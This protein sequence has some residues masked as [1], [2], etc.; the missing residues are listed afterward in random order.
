MKDPHAT[1]NLN[2]LSRLDYS[3]VQQ[4][5]HC[6]MCLPDCPTYRETGRERNS[7]RG[8]IALMRAVADGELEV[9]RAFG[10]EMY[11]C[12]GCLACQ[13]ACPADVDY[14]KLFEHARA[15]VE[16]AGAQDSPRRQVYRFLTLRLLFRFPRLL[17]WTARVLRA[18]QRSGLA[19]RVRSSGLIPPHLRHLEPNTPTIAPRFSNRL[20]APSE[21]PAGSPPRYRVAL[22]TGCI[23]DIA[24]PSVNRDCVDVL[25]AAGCQVETPPVQ[26]CCGSLHAHNGDLPG[27]RA[28][29]R[30]QLDLFSPLDRFDAILSNAGGCGSHLKHYAG[31]LP[32]DPRAHQ[33][34]AKLKDIHEFLAHIGIPAPTGERPP[35]TVAYQP[36]CHLYHGQRIRSQPEEILSRIPGLRLVPFADATTCCGSAG[37]YSITHPTT[38]QNLV[39]T[40][41][42]H[43][44]AA[45]ASAIATANPGCQLQLQNALRRR[46][47]D[48]RVAHPLTLLAEALR[49]P[50]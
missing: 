18:Y 36:S 40:K 43:I 45:G 11:Y 46:S 25:V 2:P 28:L 16:E 4:C 49:T 44:L 10:E 20:I 48:L 23:Q 5:M 3:V 32:D 15:A 29:A 26:P 9:T 39:D 42:D 22:L 6:G 17:R 35:M 30:R 8:R 34:D 50:A 12:L 38:S 14:A 1:G 21:G 19:G 47:L 27:A 41:I 24:Y 7:P 33:W 37:I 13:S 31:L